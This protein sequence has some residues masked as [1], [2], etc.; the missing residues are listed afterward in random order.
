MPKIKKEKNSMTPLG[1]IKYRNTCNLPCYPKFC[2]LSVVNVIM[3]RENVFY[4]GCEVK[5]KKLVRS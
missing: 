2:K 1:C 4:L 5:N 3:K